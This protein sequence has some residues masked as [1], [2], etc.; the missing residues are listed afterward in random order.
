MNLLVRNNLPSMLMDWPMPGSLFGRDLSDFESDLSPIR[1]GITVPSVNVSETPKE[2]KL[3]FA[4]PGMERKDFKIEVENHSLCIS[5]NKE[6]EIKE[7]DGEFTRREYSF[8][9][10]SRSFS[11]PENVKENEI[12][13]TYKNGVLLVH[14]PKM[15]ETP[16]GGARKIAIS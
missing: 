14:V 9:S 7:E 11:L 8:N 3:E 13:A 15:K 6:E 5:V 2:F 1:L 12:D 4:V 16:V 10:F